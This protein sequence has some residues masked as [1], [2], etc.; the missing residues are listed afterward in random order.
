MKGAAAVLLNSI[1]SP[2]PNST[3]MTGMSHHFLLCFRKAINS[4]AKEDRFPC[5]ICLKFWSLDIETP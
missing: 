3:K 2:N 4:P 1:K 5:D